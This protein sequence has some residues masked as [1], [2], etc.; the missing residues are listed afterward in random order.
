MSIEEQL[1][2]IADATERT[3]TATEAMLQ[4]MKGRVTALAPSPFAGYLLNREGVV[5]DVNGSFRLP[6]GRIELNRIGV[7]ANIPSRIFAAVTGSK[8]AST[9]VVAELDAFFCEGRGYSANQFGASC[10]K[11]LADWHAQLEEL[12]R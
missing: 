6:A 10:S 9:L 11:L 8:Q 7:G 12:L 4:L 3:A 5:S 1:A 2:R